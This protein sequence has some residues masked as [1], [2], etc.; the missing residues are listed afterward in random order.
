VISIGVVAYDQNEDLKANFENLKKC[1]YLRGSTA[2]SLGAG[3]THRRI[4][5][6]RR[7]DVQSDGAP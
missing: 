7:L 6:L 1:Y 4:A 3:W 5:K 2:H